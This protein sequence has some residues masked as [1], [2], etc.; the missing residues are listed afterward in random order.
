MFSRDAST[1]S[2][3]IRE[4]ALSQ[5]FFKVGIAS[6]DP[7]PDAAPF[8]NWLRAGMHGAMDYLERRAFKRLNPAKVLPNVRS[9]VVPAMNY[10]PG[11]APVDS[12]LKGRISRY[13]W[14]ADYHAAV[15]KRLER[16]LAFVRKQQPSARG[17]CYVDTGP[18]MEKVWGARTSL[19][20][21]GKHTNL[22]ARDRGSW[23]FI[24][25]ILLDLELEPDSWPKNFCGKCARC[26]EACPTG[27]IVAPYVLDARLCISYLTV[28]SSGPIPRPLR[29]LIGN[30]I[31]GCDDCQEVCPWNRFAVCAVETDLAPRDGNIA[32]DLLPLVLI[33]PREFEDRFRASPIRRATRDGFVRNVAVALGNS[34]SNEAVPALEE[35]LRDPSFL[36]RIH[37][38]WALGNIASEQAC[39]I[40]QAAAER[41]SHPAVLEEIN[42]AINPKS[43][44][45][46][47]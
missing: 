42:L 23:F 7:L 47:G 9:I 33:K 12:P 29:P 31:F 24:G 32:P 15:G 27:A 37:A 44:K 36:V 5:G 8:R 41:E 1:L 10:Y 6:V 46:P 39:R 28:E 4:E 14:G 19:G 40:L 30:R 34:G 17:V 25:V 43:R 13:A 45:L 26:M 18:V 2:S 22:I 20:W 38:A 3:R 16:L 21:M 35:V 11:R